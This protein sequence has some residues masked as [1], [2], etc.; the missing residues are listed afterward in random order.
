MGE[1]SSFRS[2]DESGEKEVAKFLDEKFYKAP[3]FERVFNKDLQIKGV[4]TTFSIGSERIYCDEKVALNYINR[5]LNTYSFELMFINRAHKEQVGWFNDS[6]KI[7]TH[8]LLCYITKCKVDKYP[9]KEDIEEMEV[10]FI[11]RMVLYKYLI[12]KG[13]DYNSIMYKVENINKGLDTDM[14]NLKNGYKFSKSPKF[15]ESPVNILIPKEVLI[16]LST[17]HRILK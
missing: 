10:I 2:K 17:I 1:I 8:Y 15:A 13:L 7:T 5:Y 11:S 9:V 16:E 12:D 4:D 3:D 6:S 14:G